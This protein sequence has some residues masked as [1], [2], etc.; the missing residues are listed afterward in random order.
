MSARTEIEAWERRRCNVGRVLVINIL[1]ARLEM[2]Q[3][4]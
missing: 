1:P 3:H 2:G 4:W